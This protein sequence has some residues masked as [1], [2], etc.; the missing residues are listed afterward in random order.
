M[1]GRARR[2][3]I[4]LVA[5]LIAIPVIGAGAGY[6]WW[7]RALPKLAGDV[8]L[9]GLGADVRVVRDR[10]GVPHIFAKSLP[11]AAR[12]LGYL[13]SQD[14]FFQMDITRRVSE[15][16]LAEIIGPRGLSL[17]RLY[18]TLD[19]AG[20]GRASY[21]ALAPDVK[22]YLQAYADGVNSWLA[23]S[24][25]A[26]PVEY[27]VL[28]F[29]PEPWRPEDS[30][31]WGKAMAWKLSAN[32]RQDASR[33]RLA[34]RVGLERAERMYPPKLPESP[35]TLKPE[36]SSAVTRGAVFGA[37]GPRFAKASDAM[38]DRL[39]ALPSVGAGASNEWVISGARSIT[40]KPLLANDPHLELNIPILWYLAR[41]TTP[42][43]TIT[44]ATAPGTPIVLL[45]QNEHIAWGSTTT[46]SDTQDLFVETETPDRAGT[47]QTP[48]GPQS[49]RS[50][51]IVIKVKG[52]GDV[53]LNRRET[54]HG[55]VISDA[56]ADAQGLGAD[57]TLISLAWTGFSTADRTAEAFYRINLAKTKDEF[58]AALQ[59]YTAP[60]QNIVYADRAGNIGFVNAGAVP[61]RKT[62]DGRYPAEGGSGASDWTGMIPFEGWPQLFNPPAGAIVNAN[63]PVVDSDYPYWFG[64]DQA[65]GYR[66]IRILERLSAKPR[67]DLASMSSIQ[68]DI[69]AA[70]ARD[71]VPFL[72]KLQPETPQERQALDLLRSWD[73]TASRDRP[74]PLILDWWLRR[75]NEDLLDASL[76]SIAPSVGGLNASVVVS[77]LRDPAGFCD[78]EEAGADCMLAVKSAFKQTLAELT[79]EYGT[80]V[81]DWRWGD[82]H[83]AEME[84]QVL[85]NVPGFRALFGVSFPSDGGFY[86]VNR[87][88]GLGKPEDN[89]PLVRRSGAGFRGVYDLADPSRSRFIIATGQ[90]GHPLS[91]FYA[92][93][94]ALYKAGESIRLN[95]TEDELSK[96]N[97]GTLIFRP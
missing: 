33:A 85:D 14:R 15:G 73:F 53:E 82:E 79:D 34:A 81:S 66:A 17:D 43:I 12:A 37:S 65:A 39:L 6:V 80:D 63:N 24:G 1:S 94:L 55:P 74:E 3:V 56:I 70:H 28:G 19:L 11:D 31:V 89:H 36:L 22:A 2:I 5:L 93:Q 91:R 71:L 30:L 76:D 44:G 4:W 35:V 20:S 86:S 23:E 42:E 45:G 75:M 88:G 7:S 68:M 48:D 60:A 59:L 40:D 52:A 92:D 54:R 96:A 77:I 9:K 67:H 58:M 78:A 26:L 29:K 64:R 51:R 57:G 32:W 49:I 47:Y 50:E 69:Q 38:L 21:A 41:I 13:H 61:I 46:D 8:Q 10:H 27:T 62:G 97:S 18:R 25:Q 84:N 87:G 83:V 16:R 72:L 90:S 95:L